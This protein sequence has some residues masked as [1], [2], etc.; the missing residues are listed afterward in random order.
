LES[1]PQLAV[2][3]G[4]RNLPRMCIVIIPR[5]IQK[6]RYLHRPCVPLRGS[7]QGLD[8]IVSQ[9]TTSQYDCYMEFENNQKCCL[10]I[11]GMC[12][13]FNHIAER[14]LQ[15]S[16]QYTNQSGLHTWT[17]LN[18]VMFTAVYSVVIR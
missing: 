15:A 6:K 14:T 12:N 17:V 7:Q 5:L 18:Q 9:H 16:R 1:S 11:G 2:V 10:I 3:I 4:I 13:V 8:A